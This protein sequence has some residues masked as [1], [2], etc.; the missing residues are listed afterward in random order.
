MSL[1]FVDNKLGE[2]WAKEDLFATGSG[3]SVHLAY[4]I[5]DLMG[6]EMEISSAPGDGCTISIQVPLPIAPLPPSLTPTVTTVDGAPRKVAVLGFDRPGDDLR[7][8]LDRLG[9]SLERQYAGLGCDI[10]PAAEADL[11]IMDGGFETDDIAPSVLSAIKAS[12]VVV[13]ETDGDKP[14][15]ITL[16]STT[17]LRRL[18]KP[19]TPS[20]IRS[21]LSRTPPRASLESN[22]TDSAVGRPRPL[23]LHF[24]S[25]SI[26]RS[27]KSFSQPD[28]EEKAVTTPKTV[29]KTTKGL[30]TLF[31]WKSRG[32]C[33]E[34][35]VASLCLGDYFS[36]RGRPRLPSGASTGS[37]G[38]S[39]PAT[40]PSEDTLGDTDPLASPG[41]GS[42]PSSPWLGTESTPVTTPSDEAP[43]TVPPAP[44]PHPMTVL[45]VEDNMVNRKILVRILKTSNLE[46]DIRESEDGADAL[47]QFKE[48]AVER[49][50]IVLLDINMPKM[51][52]FTAASE[53]RLAEKRLA[54][55]APTNGARSPTP[56][57]RSKIFAITALAGEDEKRRGLVECGMDRWLTKPCP[58]L[59]LQKVVEEACDEFNQ[60]GV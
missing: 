16:P 57:V 33:V 3:L 55:G 51:D 36:S 23:R 45:V 4:R 13:F 49:P 18:H 40:S 37:S 60:L 50:L 26:A 47:E 11:I 7:C 30:S 5:I 27:E 28:K 20:L 31:G 12:E 35:A 53:M 8:G 17:E 54:A 38:S 14:G 19:V 39:F 42:T 43:V 25:E 29:C 34:E 10:V 24:D 6:G 15:P 56:A 52:G 21:T 44:T 1:D 48:L 9:A 59:T 32:M 46:L 41:L 2:P 58:K 22:N